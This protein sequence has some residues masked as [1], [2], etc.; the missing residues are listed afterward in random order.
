MTQACGQVHL[1]ITRASGE[2]QS[3]PAGRSLVKSA[4]KVE[5]KDVPLL[6]T[7]ITQST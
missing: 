6:Q 7:S 5:E 4:K 2:E 3:D 1:W